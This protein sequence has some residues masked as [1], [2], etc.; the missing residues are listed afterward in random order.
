[1]SLTLEIC[2]SFL[3]HKNGYYCLLTVLNDLILMYNRRYWHTGKT[4][5]IP[6][7]C[8]LIKK[9]KYQEI[10]WA[11]HWY[12]NT[13]CLIMPFINRKKNLSRQTWR[14]FIHRNSLQNPT[15]INI[16]RAYGYIC[17]LGKSCDSSL[18]LFYSF[19]YVV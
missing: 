13:N 4:I 18:M 8:W 17:I 6:K 5:Y 11:Y 16:I 7:E 19:E 9:M 3:K 12:Y 10:S 1:M 15:W 2:N 14:N